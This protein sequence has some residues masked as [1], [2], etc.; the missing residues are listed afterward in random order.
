MARGRLT[1]WT[2]NVEGHVGREGTISQPSCISPVP[3]GEPRG[4][5]SPGWRAVALVG[6]LLAPAAAILWLGL[7][8][9]GSGASVAFALVKIVFAIVAVITGLAGIRWAT[10]SGSGLLVES[11]AVALWMILKV[12]TYAPGGA[13]R[14]ALLLAVPLAASGILLILADGIRAGTWPPARFREVK[15]R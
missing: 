7:T 15:T 5:Y 1:E 6:A 2:R 9:A 11:A 10:A 13:L 12:E 3:T 14:T 8:L 4:E